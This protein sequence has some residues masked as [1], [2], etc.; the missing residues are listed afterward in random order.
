M[1]VRETIEDLFI[2]IKYAIRD[3]IPEERPYIV[4]YDK[5]NVCYGPTWDIKYFYPLIKKLFDNPD[6]KDTKLFQLII[7]REDIQLYDSIY[8]YVQGKLKDGIKTRNKY[9]VRKHKHKCY[10]EIKKRSLI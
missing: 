9:S 7:D 5:D 10:I 4:M 6:T 2:T 8:E 1:G 3:C